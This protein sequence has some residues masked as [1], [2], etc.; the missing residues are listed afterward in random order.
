MADR[1]V[2]YQKHLQLLSSCAPQLRKAIL[3]NSNLDLIRCVCE[4][5]LNVLEGTVPVDKRTKTRLKRHRRLL[6]QLA[7]GNL[8]LKSKKNLIVQSGGGFLLALL[9]AV[10]SAITALVAR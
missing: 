4:C 10:I 1:V 2:K 7:R 5:C 8:G 3:Q 9:P 6:R